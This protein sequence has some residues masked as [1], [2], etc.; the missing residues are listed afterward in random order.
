MGLFYKIC[1]SSQDK[2]SKLKIVFCVG[3]CLNRRMFI[4]IWNNQ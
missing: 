2:L 1:D 4:Q 3:I